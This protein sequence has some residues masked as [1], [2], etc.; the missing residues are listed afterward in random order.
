MFDDPTPEQIKKYSIILDADLNELTNKLNKLSY[1][2]FVSIF[3][4][5]ADLHNATVNEI[6]NYLELQIPELNT[7]FIKSLLA[8]ITNILYKHHQDLSL[9]TP[10]APKLELLTKKEVEQ[11]EYIKRHG[12][13]KQELE[14]ISKRNIEA[15]ELYGLEHLGYYKNK[16]VQRTFE[17]PSNLKEHVEL[18]NT[19][20]IHD[21][22]LNYWAK[23]Y[24]AIAFIGVM[25]DY[26]ENKK[27]VEYWDNK[28]LEQQRKCN[29]NTEVNQCLLTMQQ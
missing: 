13:S 21:D 12:L 26:D 23:L 5:D 19:W 15:I 14:I 2:Y 11:Q 18:I 7:F 9:Y 6:N 20:Y 3:S 22:A 29:S 10:D 25:P 8:A 17:L 28:E 27:L 24:L 16:D 1:N 4:K